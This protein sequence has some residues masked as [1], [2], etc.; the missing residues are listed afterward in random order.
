[1]KKSKKTKPAKKKSLLS[2]AAKTLKKLG[3]GSGIGRLS[4][5]QKV[6]GGA[7]LLGGLGYLAQ[8][9]A[10]GATTGADVDANTGE[11]LPGVE[12]AAL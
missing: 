3:K 5:T 12:G 10:A 9:R 1:M 2:G 7:L 11:S 8:R 6:V 4:T